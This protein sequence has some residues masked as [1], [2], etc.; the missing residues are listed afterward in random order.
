VIARI[1]REDRYH[2]W[3]RRNGHRALVCRNCGLELT[4][5]NKASVCKADKRP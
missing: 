4:K 2:V 1:A 3:V 5:E